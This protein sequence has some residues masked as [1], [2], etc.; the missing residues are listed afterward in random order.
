M[1][2]QDPKWLIFIGIF[3]LTGLFC[4]I[5]SAYTSQNTRQFIASATEVN[6]TVVSLQPSTN[7]DGKRNGRYFA[8]VKYQDHLKQTQF[9]IS[10]GASNPPAYA[11]GEWV[12]VMY[13]AQQANYAKHA[14][15]KTFWELWTGFIVVTA[16]GVVFSLV[17][18][19]LTYFEYKK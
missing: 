15:I 8:L 17:A 9:V 18:T 10:K 11:I 1:K 16:L 5:L 13:N 14:K 6:G 12:I 3:A 7:S 2:T 19:L 4:L